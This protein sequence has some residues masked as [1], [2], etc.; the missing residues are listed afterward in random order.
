MNTVF[1]KARDLATALLE[2]EAG[3]K[4]NDARFIFDGNEEAQKQLF[5]Y[6]NFRTTLETGIRNMVLQAKKKLMHR[7]KFLTRWV[8]SLIKMQVV[9]DM[10][11]AEDEFNKFVGQVMNVFNATLS[12]DSE[13]SNG[14]CTG[15]CSTCGG[16]H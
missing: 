7:L 9:A 4:V 3:K 1:D 16:C 6:S 13:N 12:G 8:Q 10:V 11:R 15:S 5:E 2:S 14:G